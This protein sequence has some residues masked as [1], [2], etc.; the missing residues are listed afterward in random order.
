[1]RRW[2]R[3]YE[4]RSYDGLFDR[5]RQ[6]PSPKRVPLERVRPVLTLYREWYFDLKVLHFHEKLAAE[7]GITLSYTWVKTALRTAR[8][9]AKDTQHS[10]HRKAGP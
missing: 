6:Q 3:R 4:K 8:L 9:L 1:M 7:H 10:S 2:K 5:R